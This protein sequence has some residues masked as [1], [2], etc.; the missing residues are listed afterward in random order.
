MFVISCKY[1][2]KNNF[3]FNLVKD[4]RRFHETEE[5]VVVDSSSED[6]S[7]FDEIRKMNVIIEDI[8]NKNYDTGAYWYAFKKYSDRSFFYFLHDSIKIK[9]NLDYLK[10][11]D[12]T[13][14]CYFDRNLEAFKSLKNKVN[15]LTEYKYVDEGKGVFGPIF[16][17]KNSIMKKLYSKKLDVI[18]PTNKHEAA[19]MEAI[20]GNAFE[21]EGY[22]LPECSLCGDVLE[23]ESVS[24][25]SGTWPHRTGWQFP[26]EKFYALRQ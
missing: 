23:N 11:K 22:N 3:I 14:L 6:K 1:S 24:G 13:I 4:I 10:E 16:F 21:Q 15:T 25:K 17:C 19:C 20:F 5:I 9:A 2:Q 12:L 26:V 18:L 8:E 7:Y